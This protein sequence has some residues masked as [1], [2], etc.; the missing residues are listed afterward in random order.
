MCVSARQVF[1]V[2]TLSI[3]TLLYSTYS[4]PGVS[5]PKFFWYFSWPVAV[6]AVSVRPWKELIAV[7]ITGEEMPSFV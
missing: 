3:W 4:N 6:M 1:D 2:D 5:G 7:I